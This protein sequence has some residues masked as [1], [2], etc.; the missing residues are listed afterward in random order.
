MTK[1]YL[2]LKKYDLLGT[3]KGDLIIQSEK[4]ADELKMYDLCEEKYF[5]LLTEEESLALY[6]KQQMT[7]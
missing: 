2:A 3:K 1:S 6:K 4:S 5:K 7:S